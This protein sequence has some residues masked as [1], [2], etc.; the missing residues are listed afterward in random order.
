M[1]TGLP[2]VLSQTQ[3]KPFLD[4]HR[5]C[6]ALKEK[7]APAW[8]V[9]LWHVDIPVTSGPGVASPQLSGQDSSYP[10]IPTPS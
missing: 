10:P 7:A 5:R 9:E 4:A 2:A 3:R 6:P 8:H 1:A